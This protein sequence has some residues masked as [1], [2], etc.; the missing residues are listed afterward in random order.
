MLLNKSVIFILLK[1]L[2]HTITVWDCCNVHNH[3]II[4]AGSEDES[5]DFFSLAVMI[6]S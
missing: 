3:I 4:D 2:T 6:L 1:Q 5:L